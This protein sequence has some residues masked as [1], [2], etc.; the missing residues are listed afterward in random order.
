MIESFPSL[1]DSGVY[2]RKNHQIQVGISIPSFLNFKSLSRIDSG[3]WSEQEVLHVASVRL[4]P[5][6]L[7]QVVVL[8]LQ[9]HAHS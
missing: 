3:D 5:I 6:G 1:H 4:D 7:D 8:I 2:K 9:I